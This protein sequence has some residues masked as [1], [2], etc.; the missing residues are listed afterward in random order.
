METL[1]PGQPPNAHTLRQ[2]RSSCAKYITHPPRPK[3]TSEALRAPPASPVHVASER[4]ASRRSTGSRRSA[5]SRRST[6]SRMAGANGSVADGRMRETAASESKGISDAEM[7]TMLGP[8]TVGHD[9]GAWAADSLP[10]TD[11]RHNPELEKFPIRIIGGRTRR[12]YTWEEE[13]EWRRM[14][15]LQA[16]ESDAA[17]AEK[18][19]QAT[20][21]KCAV[22]QE[23]ERQMR[24]NAARRAGTDGEWSDYGSRVLADV[25]A[26]QAE[27]KAKAERHRE[28]MRQ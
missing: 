9:Y 17:E 5:G 10:G 19:R 24:D 27:L 25:D 12:T 21:R 4:A 28:T 14:A 7:W 3:K 18:R 22:R 15:E 13:G 8:A 23:Q 2:A 6:G 11:P 20:L 26:Y 16:A 1:K